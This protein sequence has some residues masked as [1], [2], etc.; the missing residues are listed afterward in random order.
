MLKTILSSTLLAGILLAVVVW[1]EAPMLTELPEPLTGPLSFALD[2]VEPPY[3]VNSSIDYTMQAGDIVVGLQEYGKWNPYPTIYADGKTVE[4]IEI[5]AGDHILNYVYSTG[6]AE[7]VEVHYESIFY[8]TVSLM[9][10]PYTY[11]ELTINP[12]LL[13]REVGY[14]AMSKLTERD[15][16]EG[17]E[18]HRST[19]GCGGGAQPAYYKLTPMGEQTLFTYRKHAVDT[20]LL[21]PRNYT[22]FQEALLAGQESIIEYPAACTMNSHTYRI[23]AGRR[24][25]TLEDQQCGGNSLQTMLADLATVSDRSRT[26]Q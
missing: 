10:K 21:L 14:R 15:I 9:V 23:K 17:F 11:S 6:G 16:K 26:V 1:H 8:D 25:L 24:V 20:T 22:Y 13:D 19:F 12:D 7:R 5:L 18:L 2:P 3:F 4:Q